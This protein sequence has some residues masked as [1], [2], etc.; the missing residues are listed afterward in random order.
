MVATTTPEAKNVSEGG[1]Q[2]GS[3]L[4]YFQSLLFSL[5]QGWFIVLG[6]GWNFSLFFS[7]FFLVSGSN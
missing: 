5:E 2:N 3:M 6:P 1:T 7:F 4:I